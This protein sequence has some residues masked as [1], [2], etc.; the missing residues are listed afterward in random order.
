MRHTKSDSSLSL[1]TGLPGDDGRVVGW[2]ELHGGRYMLAR[3]K[4]G[5]WD[6]AVSRVSTDDQVREG[7][8]L[9]HQ[10]ELAVAHA[11]RLGQEIRTVYV[12]QGISATRRSLEERPGMRILLEDIRKGRVRNI[13]VYKR[14]RISRNTTEWISF[15]SMCAQHGVNIVITCPGETP[16]VRGLTANSLKRSSLLRLSLKQV[17]PG[18]G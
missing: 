8:S 10:V 18:C 13:F 1:D 3:G 2:A 11:T 7:C 17:L 6:V 5:P 15:L 12:D 4:S 9:Q 14:D 16:V